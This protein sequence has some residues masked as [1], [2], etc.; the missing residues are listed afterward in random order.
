MAYVAYKDNEDGT[1]SFMDEGG[2]TTPPMAGPAAEQHVMKLKAQGAEPVPGAEAKTEVASGVVP[3]P[4]PPVAPVPMSPRIRGERAE[5][6]PEML[7]AGAKG[8][9]NRTAEVKAPNGSVMDAS[10]APSGAG[11]SADQLELAKLIDNGMSAED[12]KRY[13]AEHKNMRENFNKAKDWLSSVGSRFS[14]AVD[15]RKN[16][17]REKAGLPPIPTAAPPP[18]AGG[19]EKE[20]SDETVAPEDRVQLAKPPQQGLQLAMNSQS[21]PA[22]AQFKEMKVG[23]GTAYTTVDPAAQANVKRAQQNQYEAAETNTAAQAEAG[24]NV[25]GILKAVPQGLEDLETVRANI[26]QSIADRVQKDHEE[27]DTLRRE[28]RMELDAGRFWKKKSNG[29]KFAGALAMGLGAY[30]Q[31]M[32]GGPNTAMTIIN[33]AIQDD[34]MEQKE[35]RAGARE[36]FQDKRLQMSDKKAVFQDERQNF[37]AKKMGY[38]EHAQAK[39]AGFIQDAKTAEQKAQGED[40]MARIQKESA[41][42]EAEF[43]KVSHQ[44]QTKVVQV[45][46]AAGPKGS[47]VAALDHARYVPQ[48]E[49]IAPTEKEATEAREAGKQL[50]SLKYKVRQNIR[51]RN[52]PDAFVPG[53]DR[54]AQLRSNQAEIILDVKELKKLG[55]IAGPDMDL[56]VGAV[57]DNTSWKPG[58]TAAMENFI[59]N[60]EKIN[61]NMRRHLGLIPIQT[62]PVRN[63]Q[64]GE[65]EIGQVVTGNIVT[66]KNVTGAYSG[67]VPTVHI[68]RTSRQEKK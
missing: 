59:H 26:E 29:E 54:N 19:T 21:A 7:E 13:Q 61:E 34:I 67:Q 9:D 65:V 66:P 25:G 60:E 28:S 27:L 38:L 36:R 41:M 51:L 4:P 39:V 48:F 49:G 11:L 3:P 47:G 16:R 68:A 12:A 15:E 37:L 33:N 62:L 18:A 52:Q 50:D 53:T 2:Q 30:V 24:Q 1:F 35:N 6:S 46:G 40:L 17:E 5:L 20:F 42:L 10:G 64:T 44:V 55:V 31:A 58:Q 63:A 32:G 56:M 22:P 43:S 57:G 8:P 45:G 23:E 14:A